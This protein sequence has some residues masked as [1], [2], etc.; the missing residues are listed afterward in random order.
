MLMWSILV[1]SRQVAGA[2]TTIYMVRSHAKSAC[3]ANN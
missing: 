3:Y 2:H 1:M